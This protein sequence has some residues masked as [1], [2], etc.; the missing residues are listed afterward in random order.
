M[1]VTAWE[2]VDAKY[3]VSIQRGTS[4]VPDDG[5]YHVVVDGEVVLSTTV[6]AAAIAEF[7]EIREQRMAPARKLLREELGDAA[8]RSMRSAGWAEKSHRDSRK[9]GRG[10]GRR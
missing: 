4:S 2:R 5:R 9:G 7:D 6:E 8:Y 3:G 1:S 10:I